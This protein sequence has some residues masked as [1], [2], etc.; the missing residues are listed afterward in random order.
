MINIFLT[1]FYVIFAI[2][3]TNILDKKTKDKEDIRGL[4]IMY[5]LIFYYFNVLCFL[6]LKKIREKRKIN[7]YKYYIKKYEE[8]KSYFDIIAKYP[9]M[10]EFFMNYNIKKHNEIIRYLKLKKLK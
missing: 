7:Y 1:L 4:S 2:T 3:I 9:E 10:K 8:N 5:Y 6:F